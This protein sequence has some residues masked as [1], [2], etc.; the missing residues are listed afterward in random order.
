MSTRIFFFEKI[1][2]FVCLVGSGLN[3]I[4]QLKTQSRIF[5][6]SL[7]TLQA[8]TLALFTTEKREVS[9]AN[10][11]TW[12]KVINVN[13]KKLI[14]LKLKLAAHQLPPISRLRIDH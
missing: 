5:T 6:K 3:D 10:N 11:F 7:L 4:F 14:G 2:T 13:E 1:T 8:E 12:R 9:S